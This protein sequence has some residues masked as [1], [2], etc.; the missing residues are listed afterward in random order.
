M[1]DSVTTRTLPPENL[2]PALLREYRESQRIAQ[3]TSVEGMDGI[4]SY[5][6]GFECG[7]REGL[8]RALTIV[9]GENIND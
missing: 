6:Y 8:R 2:A 7:Y 1:K 9:T 3:R 4:F 5:G